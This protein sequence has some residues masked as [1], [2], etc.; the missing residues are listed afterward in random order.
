MIGM[1]VYGIGDKHDVR[2]MDAHNG[3]EFVARG[4]IMHDFA[5]F[6]AQESAL[7]AE[8]FCCCGAFFGAGFDAAVW[9]GLAVGHVDQMHLVAG[10]EEFD[11][12]ARP[13]RFPDRRDGG[14]LRGSL[15]WEHCRKSEGKTRGL[16]L[17]GLSAFTIWSCEILTNSIG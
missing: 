3:G 14:R 8:D 15:P 6:Q 16:R 4:N 17:I 5:I 11:N 10:R 13:C 7:A 12:G 2:A 9:G 1:G